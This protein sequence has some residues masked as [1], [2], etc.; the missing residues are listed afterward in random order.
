[1]HHLVVETPLPWAYTRPNRSRSLYAGTGGWRPNLLQRRGNHQ[2]GTR[3]KS[4]TLGTGGEESLGG[5]NQGG[6]R[7]TP[8]G[9]ERVA[10]S[11]SPRFSINGTLLK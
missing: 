8:G 10:G 6:I 5:T 7:G 2:S 4:A 3:R 1:M 11:V 9:V